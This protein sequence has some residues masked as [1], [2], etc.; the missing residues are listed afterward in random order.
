MEHEHLYK[1][2]GLLLLALINVQSWDI[3]CDMYGARDHE[4]RNGD[5]DIKVESVLA[6]PSKQV[7]DMN[8]GR[9]L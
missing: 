6:L 3:M 8:E 4:M 2:K 7:N 5:C 9:R 1:R